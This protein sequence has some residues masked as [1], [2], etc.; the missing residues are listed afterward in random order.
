MNE[1]D[2]GLAVRF[3]VEPVEQP[4][5]SR[6]E[7]RPIFADVEMI[8]IAFPGDNKR[9]LVAPAKEMHFDGNTRQSLTYAERFAPLYARFKE[10]IAEAAIGTPLIAATFLTPS[11]VAE[12]K[13]VRITTVE[14]L[15]ALDDPAIRRLGMGTRVLVEQAKSYLSA[16]RD[17]AQFSAMQREIEE[18]KAR[19]AEKDA[20]P[21]DPPTDAFAMYDDDTLR[22]I[23]ADKAGTDAD[24]RWGRKTLVEK[25]EAL[26]GKAA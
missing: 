4:N 1:H 20:P 26:V 21:D 8:E 2:G 9:R 16:A 10:G 12:L 17:T 13:G 14:Q 11:K 5:R 24:G 22:A 19:L 7:G 3:F 6:E 25:I 15:A 18:L 23:Y